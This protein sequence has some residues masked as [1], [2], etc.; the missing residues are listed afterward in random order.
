V[1]AYRATLDI[2]RELAQLVSKLLTDELGLRWFPDRTA[3]RRWPATT[4]SY[5]PPLTGTQT[6]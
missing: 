1:I 3:P 4:G 2:T 5:G 6:R